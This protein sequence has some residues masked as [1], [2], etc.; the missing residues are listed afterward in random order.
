[1]PSFSKLLIL[2]TLLLS[3][4]LSLPTALPDGVRGK[5][6]AAPK[7]DN[8]FHFGGDFDGG[9]T[10]DKREAI[11]NFPEP[12]KREAAPAPEADNSFHF[13]GDFEGGL[14]EDKREAEADPE[15][16][17]TLEHIAISPETEKRDNSF[18]FG[19]DFEGGLTEDKR[20]SS[21]E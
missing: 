5:R 8:S 3:G 17:N 2:S 10:E 12:K 4:V 7:P 9:L 14:T 13:G 16:H 6:E 18:H 19:G 20:D 21:D 1:M 11:P 15:A